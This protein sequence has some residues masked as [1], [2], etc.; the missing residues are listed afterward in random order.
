MNPNQT[1]IDKLSTQVQGL[2]GQLADI[3]K[4]RGL[5]FDAKTNTAIPVSTISPQQL[6]TSQTPIKTP[7]YTQNSSGIDSFLSGINTQASQYAK[8]IVPENAALK[9]EVKN[10]SQQILDMLAGNMGETALTDKAYKDAGVDKYKK[11]LDTLNAELEKRTLEYRRQIED[12]Q[13]GGGNESVKAAEVS[14][15]SQDATRELA[16]KAILVNAARGNYDTAKNIADRAV[17][18]Q[19]ERQTSRLNALE[20]WYDQNKE[21]LNKEEQRRYELTTSFMENQIKFE[22]DKELKKYD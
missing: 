7:S 6:D 4:A 12:V 18:L 11:E 13:K 22:Q 9:S 21:T 15:I 8:E 3:F 19:T 1:T 17:A 2:Y 20:W 14:R 16:D 10:A 5:T